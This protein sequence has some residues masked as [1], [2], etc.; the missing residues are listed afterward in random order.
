M[1]WWV[2]SPINALSGWCWFFV[3]V[4]QSTSPGPCKGR[5]FARYEFIVS[6]HQMSD[7][8]CLGVWP[9]KLK[10]SDLKVELSKK[11]SNAETNSV[12]VKLYNASG[13]W[14]TFHTSVGRKC[15]SPGQIY[16]SSHAEQN[17]QTEPTAAQGRSPMM[18]DYPANVHFAW[19][20][21][22]N[23]KS[24]N[25]RLFCFRHLWIINGKMQMVHPFFTVWC[26]VH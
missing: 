4:A 22:L 21:R 17:K 15:T 23:S 14:K 1:H 7:F 18:T 16:V 11:R 6:L 9:I 3:C 20:Y 26:M 2:Q 10:G 5:T 12:S 24:R 8:F 25:K 19:L 13:K